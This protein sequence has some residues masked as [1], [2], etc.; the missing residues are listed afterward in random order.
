[1]QPIVDFLQSLSPLGVLA[2]LCGIS[3][4]ENIFPPS[5]S[6]LIIVFGGTLVGIGTVGFIPALL[7]TTL[8]SILGF[9]TAFWVGKEFGEKLLEPGRIKFI[10][11]DAVH[12]V[13][14]WFRKYGYRIIVI[15]RFLSGT[16]AVVSFVA[17]MSEMRVGPT[18][19]LCG[20][21]ALVWNGLLLFAGMELG[22][23]W[24]A[25]AAFLETYGEAVT[26]VVIVLLLILSVRWFYTRKNPKTPA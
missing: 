25:V 2:V 15:N 21:S 6:D 1:M 26:V 11:V 22:H 12:K 7:C 19:V 4:L 20:I 17:G 5:P 16:R 14:E 9:L 24:L 23:N 10:S 8:G 18:A 13:E 3:Y